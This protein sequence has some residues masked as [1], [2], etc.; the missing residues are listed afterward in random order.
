[1]S[2]FTIQIPRLLIYEYNCLACFTLLPKELKTDCSACQFPFCIQCIGRCHLCYAPMCADCDTNTI[3]GCCQ[4][5]CKVC[6]SYL[7]SCGCVLTIDRNGYRNEY[8]PDHLYGQGSFSI[9]ACGDSYHVFRLIQIA[10][11]PARQS[12]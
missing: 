10:M 2:S 12:E 1:M 9:R 8:F 5:Q 3:P 4:I 7:C 6:T 11:M